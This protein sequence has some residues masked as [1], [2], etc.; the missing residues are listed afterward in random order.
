MLVLENQLSSSFTGPIQMTD[1]FNLGGGHGER[2]MNR[3]QIY[4]GHRKDEV[5]ERLN[6]RNQEKLQGQTS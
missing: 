2:N 4:S 1:D 3:F 6:A 5:S